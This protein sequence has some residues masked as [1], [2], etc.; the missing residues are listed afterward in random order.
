MIWSTLQLTSGDFLLNKS[1]LE[2]IY[3]LNNWPPNSDLLLNNSLLLEL[4]YFL[5]EIRSFKY[6]VWEIS[7][8][9]QWANR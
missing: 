5:I 2:L 8:S 1:L 9:L 3:F 7:F 4:I 6:I